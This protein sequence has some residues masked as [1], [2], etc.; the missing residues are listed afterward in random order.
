MTNVL[1]YTIPISRRDCQK[2]TLFQTK[3]V[4]WM[5]KNGNNLR[6]LHVIVLELSTVLFLLTSICKLAFK[7]INPSPL[8]LVVIVNIRITIG[9]ELAKK[10]IIMIQKSKQQY[11]F[12]QKKFLPLQDRLV[13]L[14]CL[15]NKNLASHL[16]L[17]CS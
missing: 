1:F 9:P 14:I 3:I 4:N 8:Q 10:K 11:Y 5:L 17:P 12:N 16:F 15:C 6:G 7:A 13:C 2:A